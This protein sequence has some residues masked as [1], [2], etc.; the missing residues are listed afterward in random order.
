MDG[1]GTATA[2]ITARELGAGTVVAG[3]PLR[4]GYEREL[5][6]ASVADAAV[7]CGREGRAVVGAG[8]AAAAVVVCTPELWRGRET[9]MLCCC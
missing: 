8:I 2:V 9:C 4:V 7:S 3:L 5:W 6:L 1:A